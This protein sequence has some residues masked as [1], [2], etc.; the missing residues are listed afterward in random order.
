MRARTLIVIFRWHAI[1]RIV[2]D[3]WRRFVESLQAWHTLARP[4]RQTRSTW[5]VGKPLTDNLLP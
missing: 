4:A 1:V 3:G 5:Q 2:T